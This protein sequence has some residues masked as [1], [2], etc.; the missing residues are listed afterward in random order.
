MY[1]I[2]NAVETGNSYISSNDQS[3]LTRRMH[4]SD[5]GH[6]VD[7]CDRCRRC[8]KS[9]EKFCRVIAAFGSHVAVNNPR[10]VGFYSR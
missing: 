4:G 10:W 7:T 8:G 5:C 1:R 6:I 9:E 2:C 3:M